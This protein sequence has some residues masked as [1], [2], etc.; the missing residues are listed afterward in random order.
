LVGPRPSERLLNPQ[1]T[2]LDFPMIVGGEKEVRNEEKN[3]QPLK[4][5]KRREEPPAPKGVEKKRRE[6]SPDESGCRKLHW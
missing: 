6:G 1:E 4:G 5:W 2:P 3:P